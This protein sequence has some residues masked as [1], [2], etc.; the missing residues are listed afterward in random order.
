MP[1][2]H[3]ALSPAMPAHVALLLFD[4][5]LKHDPKPTI[6][7]ACRDSSPGRVAQSPPSSGGGDEMN[8]SVEC[9]FSPLL[10]YAIAHNELRDVAVSALV[11]LVSP[12]FQDGDAHRLHVEKLGTVV[13]P[14]H[15]AHESLASSP[16]SLRVLGEHVPHLVEPAFGLQPHE[17]HLESRR[18]DRARRWRAQRLDRGRKGRSAGHSGADRSAHEAPEVIRGPRRELAR[19]PGEERLDPGPTSKGPK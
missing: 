11:G 17:P 10:P 16:R 14:R 1:R 7:A 12:P 4:R 6:S 18:R 5:L 2:R 8:L 13:E 3:S 9:P 19:H 15:V